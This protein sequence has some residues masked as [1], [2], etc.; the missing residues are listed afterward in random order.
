M[1]KDVQSLVPQL[2]VIYVGSKDP[3]NLVTNI[4]SLIE[5]KKLS[6]SLSL[7]KIHFFWR[8][9]DSMRRSKVRH[10]ETTD[11][12]HV[13]REVE[14]LLHNNEVG[15]E[16]W[17]IIGR[18]PSTNIIKLG[19]NEWMKFLGQYPVWRKYLPSIGLV[20][21]IRLFLEP[22]PTEPCSDSRIISYNEG[23]MEEKVLCEIC[24][25]PM[26]KFIVYDAVQ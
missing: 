6:N 22:P 15:H 1:I 19:A 10:G 21:A 13:L 25:H 8:R 16:N 3:S 14:A 18:G 4:V 23:M 26:E 11:T 20:D 9:L 5:S 17:M 2:E 7:T 12:D 24:K